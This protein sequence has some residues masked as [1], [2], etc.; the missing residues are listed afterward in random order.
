VAV[1]LRA[2]VRRRHPL[3]HRRQGRQREVDVRARVVDVVELDRDHVLADAQGVRRDHEGLGPRV[4]ER[5]ARVLQ[6]LRDRR[7]LVVGVDLDAVDVD[8]HGVVVDQRP[9]EA[10]DRVERGLVELEGGPEEVGRDDRRGGAVQVVLQQRRDRE[11]RAQVRAPV[12]G[13][14]RA[15]AGLPGARQRGADLRP[16]RA[17][18][19]GGGVDRPVVEVRP[20][21]FGRDQGRAVAGRVAAQRPVGDLEPR[22]VRRRA[23]RE[24]RGDPELV[25]AVGAR[26]LDRVDVA[27]EAR[28]EALVAARV[29]LDPG[30]VVRVRGGRRVVAA[31]DRPVLGVALRGVVGRGERVG[32]HL[33]GLGQ[34]VDRPHRVRGRGLPAVPRVPLLGRVAVPEELDVLGRAVVVRE[35][36]G[37]RLDELVHL[38]RVAADLQRRR[39]GR[40][41][42]AQASSA[43][44]ASSAAKRDHERRCVRSAARRTDSPPSMRK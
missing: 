3:A 1:E 17:V 44:T 39:L 42:G 26:V 25:V 27:L 15:Q 8:R 14:E 34:R 41:G 40:R 19:A 10:L 22:V 29:E 4:G 12:L 6:V 7:A 24:V 18:G 16:G 35:V 31:E 13:A 33:G 20:L 9:V 23:V 2:R 38:V 36:R 43:P 21:S 5:P 37:H 11:A 32:R 28:L 30:G